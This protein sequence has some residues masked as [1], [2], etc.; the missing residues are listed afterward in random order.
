MLSYNNTERYFLSWIKLFNQLL[1]ALFFHHVITSVI[2]IH[3]CPSCHMQCSQRVP[4]RCSV[5]SFYIWVTQHQLLVSPSLWQGFT[6]WCVF[7]LKWWNT[8]CCFHFYWEHFSSCVLLEGFWSSSLFRYQMV[9]R[10]WWMAL[11]VRHKSFIIYNC[12]VFFLLR[13]SRLI[14]EFLTL[15]CTHFLLQTA[16]YSALIAGIIYGKRRY[17]KLLLELSFTA[18]V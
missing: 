18:A 17:G 16:R 15:T 3:V 6:R 5:E 13:L 4:Q 2:S 10:G 14:V 12:I 1:T 7:C 9:I 8:F 11:T